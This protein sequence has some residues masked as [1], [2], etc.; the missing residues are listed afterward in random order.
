MKDVD[1]F[2]GASSTLP[3]ASK[4]VDPFP[5]AFVDASWGVEGRRSFSW[6]AGRPASR[7]KGPPQVHDRRHAHHTHSSVHKFSVKYGEASPSWLEAA[8]FRLS[9]DQLD[10][11]PAALFEILIMDHDDDGPGELM[12]RHS[13]KLGELVRPWRDAH[14]A[15]LRRIEEIEM[16]VFEK[17]SELEEQLF[18]TRTTLGE[19]MP[20]DEVDDACD[21]EEEKIEA[22][23]LRFKDELEA[24]HAPLPVDMH[25]QWLKLKNGPPGQPGGSAEIV[26]HWAHD[27]ELAMVMR[28]EALLAQQAAELAE[29][30]VVADGPLPLPCET[31]AALAAHVALLARNHRQRPPN[32][33][34]VIVGRGRDLAAGY[35]REAV[36]R[37]ERVLTPVPRAEA[38]VKLAAL[39]LALQLQADDGRLQPLEK[40]LRRKVLATGDPVEAPAGDRV[41]TWLSRATFR[42]PKHERAV[43]ASTI[44]VEVRDRDADDVQKPVGVCE[45]ALED[46]SE[47]AKTD[48]GHRQ[49]VAFAQGSV[50]VWCRLF[51]DP[52]VVPEE[53]LEDEAESIGQKNELANQLRVVV[54]GARVRTRKTPVAVNPAPGRG[55]GLEV[56]LSFL[57]RDRSTNVAPWAPAEETKKT[58]KHACD[59]REAFDFVAKDV[60]DWLDVSLTE[61]APDRSRRSKRGSTRIYMRDLAHRHSVRRWLAM[62]SSDSEVGDVSEV[63][64]V[65]R[66]THSLRLAKFLLPDPV[67]ADTTQCTFDDAPPVPPR[68]KVHVS[69]IAVSTDPKDDPDMDVDLHPSAV[70]R[71]FFAEGEEIGDDPEAIGPHNL[72]EL[73]ELWRRKTVTNDTRMWRQ[74]LDNWTRVDELHSLKRI[75][76]DYPSLPEPLDPADATNSRTW[77]VKAPPVEGATCSTGIFHRPL[78]NPGDVLA[79]EP[80]DWRKELELLG[81]DPD[82]DLAVELDAATP[83]REVEAGAAVL[84]PIEGPFSSGELRDAYETGRLAE[85]AL[86]WKGPGDD[87]PGEDLFGMLV[88][89]DQ[90]PLWGRR[91]ACLSENLLQADVNAQCELCGCLATLHSVDALGL[92]LNEGDCE[93]S[94]DPS[95]K[96]PAR[97]LDAENRGGGTVDAKELVDGV[98]WAGG[99]KAAS[100]EARAA[101][102]ATHFLRILAEAP[103]KPPTPP[104]QKRTELRDEELVRE[105]SDWEARLCQHDADE[106]D[107][108]ERRSFARLCTSRGRQS[109]GARIAETGAREADSA[110]A[111]R[112][113][114]RFGLSGARLGREIR[115]RRRR[116]RG[117][118][119]VA[120]PQVRRVF[121]NARAAQSRGGARASSARGRGRRAG[122]RGVCGLRRRRPL[123]ESDDGARRLRR[124][125]LKREAPLDAARRRAVTISVLR[126][127]GR[128]AVARVLTRRGARRASRRL[129]RA[130]GG[131]VGR[132]PGL[133][134]RTASSRRSREPYAGRVDRGARGSRGIDDRRTAVLRGLLRGLALRARRRRRVVARRG[135]GTA[136]ESARP[137]ARGSRPAGRG[138]ARR[139]TRGRSRR[140]RGPRA[141]FDVPRFGRVE[142]LSVRILILLRTSRGRRKQSNLLQ[143][144]AATVLVR[145][146]DGSSFAG[147]SIW[148]RAASATPGAPRSRPRCCTGPRGSAAR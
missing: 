121:R 133:G 57:G 7:L 59:I 69:S 79:D 60:R 114:P 70:P 76:W 130:G 41:P 127:G 50:D 8:H 141:E 136:P 89:K 18:E 47:N 5:G 134:R 38:T 26:V 88:D 116:A 44:V 125:P 139:P 99:F 115:R 119:R 34:E 17:R 30:K 71:W 29:A 144:R 103:P 138:P 40:R 143:E 147:T 123:K 117:R 12:G 27:V 142:I 132:S 72:Y 9:P 39:P 2:P 111:A 137:F 113:R 90:L 118:Y 109:V 46:I 84:D 64:V 74:G 61:V 135:G 81:D 32:T 35:R 82:L 53:V 20:A 73:R 80:V 107:A 23:C 67:V 3:E 52:R 108:A 58:G 126:R 25:R 86:L 33:V 85:D 92:Q 11:D 66:L 31:P 36:P 140:G 93:G 28:E 24:E 15:R 4:D 6:G 13:F 100:P 37:P 42:L 91:R 110:E 102:R 104:R 16:R 122:R 75:L 62:A 1:P 94:D 63:E 112:A 145:P 10:E 56:A 49:W 105:L 87:G 97:F 106:Y 148:P 124:L 128:P 48:D 96:R 129:V 43:D 131:R 14:S 45:V 95:S 101:L 65:V 146:R 22:A 68:G 21:A 51:Y 19:H 77:F 54:V 83:R 78:P 98:V 120:R 55:G